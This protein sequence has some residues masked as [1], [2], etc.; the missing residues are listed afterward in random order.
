MHN[1]WI[2]IKHE[3][4]TT[5]AKRSFW[6]T[7]FLLP[8]AIFA[9]SFGSQA[10]SQ[11]AVAQDGSN[12][13]FGGSGQANLPVGYVDGAGLIMTMPDDAPDGVS[14]KTVRLRA[15]ADEAAAQTALANGKINKYY[16]V[17]ADYVQSGELIVVDS[18]FSVFNSLDNNEFFEYVLQLNLTGD[19]QVARALIDPTE[20]TGQ[21][22]LAPQA[23][24]K[25]DE[26]AAFGVP[27][28]ALFIFFFVITMTGG[29][30]LQS[31]SK[32]K[33]NRTIEVLLLSVRPR[34]VMLGKIAGLGMV[35]LLQ[36]VVWVGGGLLLMGRD[37][38]SAVSLPDG[39]LI[40]ALLYFVLGYLLYASVLGALGALAPSARE[41]TQFTFLVLLP[42]MIPLWMS[43]V[44]IQSPNEA[45]SIIFSLFPLTSPTSMITRLAAGPVPIEQLL[46]GLGLLAVTTYGLIALSARFFRADTLL[47]MNSLNLK[48]IVYELRR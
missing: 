39:F 34:D 37:Q 9:L 17:P 30:M 40:W 47:A 15:Y 13:L 1:V 46:I 42:L 7:T 35:A 12:P 19:A 3:M 25:K 21:Y 14:W 44:L 29:F 36:V 48:R 31:V 41:G 26:M 8:V 28:A 5:L 2:I 23:V 11:S 10:L 32:E 18:N 33:E 16:L 20:Q 24:A 27:F 43:N 45:M 4:K 6:L 38:M 22:G